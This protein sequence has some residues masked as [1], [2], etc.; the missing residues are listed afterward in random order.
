MKNPTL[1]E[2]TVILDR[3]QNLVQDVERLKQSVSVLRGLLA[4]QICGKDR[5]QLESCVEQ[6]R[7]LEE[8]LSSPTTQ[9]IAL[10]F[11]ALKHLLRKGSGDPDA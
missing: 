9:D 7:H 2:I 11:E 8:R 6:I 10:A 4:V 1:K 5:D 3:A